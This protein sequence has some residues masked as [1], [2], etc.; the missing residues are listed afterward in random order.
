MGLKRLIVFVTR[1]IRAL[2]K[3]RLLQNIKYPIIDNSIDKDVS[4][5]QI[6]ISTFENSK[7]IKHIVNYI[8]CYF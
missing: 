1:K 6:V 3:I 4:T 8:F 5:Q 7:T 2:R